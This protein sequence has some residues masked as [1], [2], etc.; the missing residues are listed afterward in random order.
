M[1]RSSTRRS[2]GALSSPRL[3]FW[4]ASKRKPGRSRLPIWSAR[5]IGK[6]SATLE[7]HHDTHGKALGAA[8]MICGNDTCEA[9]ASV[10]GVCAFN[11]VDL[12]IATASA[13]EVAGRLH[14][15]NRVMYSI[16][17]AA[18]DLGLLGP[19]VRQALGMAI[20]KE[21]IIRKIVKSGGRAA[22]TMTPPGTAR[23]TPPAG[24]PY[25][26]E[27]ARQLLAEA[28]YPGGKGFPR[29]QYMFNGGSGGAGGSSARPAARP[30]GRDGSRPSRRR[31]S[32]SA[33]GSACN[34]SSRHGRGAR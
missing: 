13:A 31:S 22:S 27:K 1:A 2:S 18:L 3:N 5:K 29:L 19:K 34:G 20:D 30:A 4:C 26:P 12:G 15:D 24:L 16:G 25:D 32:R 33:A 6:G 11:S 8:E 14:V 21:R 9:L 23:Y 10:E 17:R 28:G 7:G